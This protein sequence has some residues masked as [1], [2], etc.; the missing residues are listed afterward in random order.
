MKLFICIISMFCLSYVNAQK[1]PLTNDKFYCNAVAGIDDND[2]TDK[3]G[4][5]IQYSSDT[6]C[7][8]YYKGKLYTGKVKKCKNNKIESI[9]NYVNG[10]HEGVSFSYYENGKLAEYSVF[11]KDTTE[12]EWVLETQRDEKGMV[13]G[14]EQVKVCI[15]VQNGEDL[16]YHENG[17]LK[18]KRLFLNGKREGQW[19]FYDE[20]GALIEIKLFKDDKEDGKWIFYDEKGAVM[21]I[22]TFKEGEEISC[23]GKCD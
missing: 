18:W 14:F 7:N 9:T 21:T 2:F 11:G 8:R 17:K 1:P 3:E 20:K 4:I 5:S 23:S 16:A 19:Y 10:R 12:G 13:L 6:S 15:G 22:R